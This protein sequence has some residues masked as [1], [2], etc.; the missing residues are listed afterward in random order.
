MHVAVTWVDLRLLTTRLV[1][2][3]FRK[4]ALRDAKKA[5]RD[6][7]GSDIKIEF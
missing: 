7:A 3:N 4:K 1:T 2:D 6:A 5:L